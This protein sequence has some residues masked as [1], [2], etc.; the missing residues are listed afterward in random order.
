M[1]KLISFI[2]IPCL[3]FYLTGCSGMGAVT[4]EEFK[5]NSVKGKIILITKNLETY[6]F[7][8]G[9][10]YIESDTL[11]GDGEK[12]IKNETGIPFKGKIPL[13]I[14]SSITMEKTDVVASIFLGIGII[15]G[16]GVICF[17]VFMILM[18][19][20]FSNAFSSCGRSVRVK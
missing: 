19:S 15:A 6:H 4:K 9:Y 8:E 7:D 10:Y 20:A 2:L 18:A 17:G 11:Y 3:F 12:L 13:N 1:K 5:K 14:I 16:I